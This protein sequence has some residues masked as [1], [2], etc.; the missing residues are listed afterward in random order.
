LIPGT[1]DLYANEDLFKALDSAIAIARSLQLRLIIPFIDRW[2]W[3]G[4]IETFAGLFRIIP[5]QFYTHPVIKS[6]FLHVVAYVVNRVNTVN[7]IPYK[8]DPTIA[9][10]EHGNELC[11]VDC[12]RA[13]S[14]WIIEVSRFIKSLDSNHLVLDGSY[15][16]YGWDEQVLQEPSIDV[17]SNH[18][19]QIDVPSDPDV[20]P[21]PNSWSWN[22]A[23]RMKNEAR[24]VAGYGK[25]FLV[26]E[27]GLAPVDWM[28]DLL[29][30]AI[31][32]VECSGV[33][34]WSLRYRSRDGG[35]CK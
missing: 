27:A 15:G 33:L 35:F 19:Y 6:A 4:G 13:P 30:A 22:Y 17:Y 12:Q 2:H 9:M 14:E 25:A 32:T 29:G 18:Y 21:K 23:G 11:T 10:W 34:V 31:T 8:N 16:Y 5:T 26:G 3:W 1:V 7:G 24:Y 28:E 20:R